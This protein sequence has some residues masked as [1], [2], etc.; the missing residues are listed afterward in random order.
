[1]SL[2]DDDLELQADETMVQR[3]ITPF[4][5][6]SILENQEQ[7]QKLLPKIVKAKTL[8]DEVMQATGLEYNYKFGNDITI[9]AVY[10][11]SICKIPTYASMRCS[12]TRL[13]KALP[14]IIESLCAIKDM[15]KVTGVNLISNR[16]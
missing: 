4:V 13:E 12:Y 7:Y 1:M 3:E 2:L 6:P 9:M 11:Y 14:S 5:W 8:I 16:Q 15:A 10:A